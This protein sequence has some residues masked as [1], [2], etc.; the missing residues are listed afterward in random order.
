MPDILQDARRMVSLDADLAVA[1]ARA[2]AVNAAI[3][4][5]QARGASEAELA[6][7]AEERD[8]ALSQALAVREIIRGITEER[9]ATRAEHLALH[10]P[11]VLATSLLTNRPARFGRPGGPDGRHKITGSRFDEGGF[12]RA[13]FHRATRRDALGYH[14]LTGTLIGP[15]GRLPDGRHYTEA[16]LTRADAE[17]STADDVVAGT[18]ALP[19]A[20]KPTSAAR[21]IADAKRAEKS[22]VRPAKVATPTPAVEAVALPVASRLP[23][24]PDHD[25]VAATVQAHG[26]AGFLSEAE[27]ARL[28]GADREGLDQLVRD[29]PLERQH[30]AVEAN[31][32]RTLETRVSVAS[33][34]RVADTARA[35]AIPRDDAAHEPIRTKTAARKALGEPGTRWAQVDPSG[36]VVRTATV[37]RSSSTSRWSRG[38]DDKPGQKPTYRSL[39]FGPGWMVRDDGLGVTDPDGW[40]IVR[41]A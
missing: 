25:A 23:V 39:E 30:R 19:P 29:G 38:D 13:G 3:R 9:Q 20:P 31:G 41:A 21:T 7:L 27:A 6:G 34:A 17:L 10:A 2:R 40:S 5:A 35:T 15:D 36:R 32:A 26:T 11:S 37:V 12:T 22:D 14:E 16:G 33:V 4:D 24:N 18:V 8:A 28:L 1:R